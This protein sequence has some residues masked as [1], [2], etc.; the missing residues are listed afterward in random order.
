LELISAPPFLNSAQLALANRA[1][2]VKDEVERD[3]DFSGVGEKEEGEGD[4]QADRDC[5]L[6]EQ[7][8]VAEVR[9]EEQEDDQTDSQE[10]RN[11][12]VQGV[13]AEK[14][15]FFTLECDLAVGARLA[16]REVASKYAGQSAVGAA[17][18]EGSPHG[19]EKPVPGVVR[20]SPQIGSGDMAV[21][22]SQTGI[23]V[24]RCGP[25]P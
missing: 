18:G 4:R 2:W 16:Q 8:E 23:N 25:P 6:P 17:A 10:F 14:V 5:F 15:A 13:R 1:R 3:P 21:A 9:A 24:L 12:E 19:D 20:E 22:G 7:F 11:D